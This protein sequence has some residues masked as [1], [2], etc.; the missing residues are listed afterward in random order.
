MS[1]EFL[2]TKINFL[3][4][5]ELTVV[6]QLETYNEIRENLLTGIFKEKMNQIC[7]K[8]HDLKILVDLFKDSSK[9]KKNYLKWLPLTTMDTER[10]FSK[11]GLIFSR[12]RKK[13]SNET[14][15]NIFQINNFK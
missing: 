6:D 9:P 12:L 13:L 15:N 4:G 2:P 7:S 11:Y 3:E 1:F 14:I 10:S 5:Q 8:N